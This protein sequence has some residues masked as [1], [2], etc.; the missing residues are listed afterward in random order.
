MNHQTPERSGFYY[1]LGVAYYALGQFE[2]AIEGY[3]EAVRINPKYSEAYHNRG[4][5]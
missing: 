1:S 4:N 5:D 3:D 2:S